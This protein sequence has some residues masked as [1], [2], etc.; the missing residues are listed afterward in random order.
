M[1]GVEISRLEPDDW[2]L[3]RDV[4]LAA[5]ADAPGAFG[6]TLEQELGYDEARWRERLRPEN[7]VRFAA[8][9][10]GRAVGLAGAWVTG[11]RSGVAELVSMWVD[12][13]ARGTGTAALLVERVVGWAAAQGHREIRLW[14]VDGNDRAAGLYR[15][16]GFSATGETQPYPNAAGVLEHLMVR[17]L[18][19]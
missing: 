4:R 19:P 18:Q 17:P 16:L 7:G 5:L 9:A 11:D 1:I 15:R 8:V 3:F 13:A 10:A 14:V 12:P 6:A 2:K